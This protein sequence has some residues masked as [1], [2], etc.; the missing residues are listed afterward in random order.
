MPRADLLAL[1]PDDL[2]AMTNR[3]TLKRAQREVENGECT[4]RLEE[5]GGTVT[6]R[7]S[8]GV[9]CVLPAGGSL[10]EGRCSC[11]A[12]G[13]C[14]HLVR[15]VLAYRRQGLPAPGPPAAQT[16]PGPPGA[17]DPGAVAD[18]ELAR[19][20]RPAVLARLRAEFDKGVLAEVVRGP[21]PTARFPLGGHLV[22]F[23][24]PG[25]VRYTHCDCAEAPPCPHVP[26]AVWAFRL[27]EP[28]RVSAVIAR[29]E[30]VA[31]APVPLLD[32]VESALEDLAGHGLSGVGAAGAGRLTRLEESCRGADLVWPAEVL[33]DLLAQQQ[34]YAA[35]DALFSPDEV[36]TLAG[37][38][39]ARLDAVRADTGALPQPLVRGTRAD[40]PA[41]LGAARFIGLGCAAAAG[42]G[43]AGLTAY[44]QD[45]DTGSLVTLAKEFPDPP[46]D[47]GQRPRDF[48]ELAQSAAVR[49]SSLATLGAGQLTVRGARR[50]AGFRLQ[51]TRS[52]AAVN[53]QDFGWESLRPP[54]L[55][56]DFAELQARL[57]A[58]A[59]SALR[60]RRQGEDFHVCAVAAV[61]GAGFD[62]PTQAVRA[63]L[64][65]ARGARA[66]L[67]HAHTSRGAAGT[68]ALLTLLGERP[69][70]VRFVAGPVRR[71]ATG[72]VLRPVCVVYQDGGRRAALQPWVERGAGGAGGSRPLP[73][74]APCEP[75]AEALAELVAALGDLFVVGLA[76]ADDQTARRWAELGRRA[77]ASGLARVARPVTRLAAALEQK[78]HALHWDWRPAARLVLRL[79]V[80]ARL[81][82]DL[83]G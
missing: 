36:A 27:L 7:W 44:L 81:A 47:S 48:A 29:G 52:Q 12:A 56:E 50:T 23:L 20:F 6:A 1:S 33:A 54:V 32:E 67:A 39:L 64:V 53:P 8:D 83:V 31:P 30:L 82:L 13:L 28:G 15:T 60:P 42:R 5:E 72:L 51:V 26:P 69:G 9:E 45:S 79:A 63:V 71:E 4:A 75:L 41:D 66:A 11:A 24:V 22:R 68:E 40:R 59:P 49:G 46:A 57:D 17:W 37:E 73:G 43:R 77:G 14:R 55:V 62:L 16:S 70:D 65:D 34:R 80:L 78:R 19:H 61:E 74:A 58:L 2:A 3:G 35:H 76:R 18:E 25:D 38:L 10:R 21:K